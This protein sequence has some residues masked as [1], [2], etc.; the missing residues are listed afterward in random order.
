MLLK[1]QKNVLQFWRDIEIF[2]LPDMPDKLNYLET[3]SPL[4]WAI[5]Q[6]P[7]ED[8]KRRYI[9]YFGKQKKLHITGLI[10]KFTGE[11]EEKPDWM[12]KVTGDTCMAV[13]ILEEEGTLSEE[14]A[15]LQASYLHGL[16]CLQSGKKMETVVEMLEKVQ[17]DFID[18]HNIKPFTAE[19]EEPIEL[20]T[21]GWKE[22]ERE[23]S[24]LNHLNINSLECDHTVYCQSIIISK[25]IKNADTS[26]LNSF[27][28]DDLNKL[29]NHPKKWNK[30]LNNYLSPELDI[31]QRTDL[32]KEADAFFK[33]I[34]PDK[35]P[36]G[37]W[38]SNPQFGAYSAQLGAM[39]TALEELKEGGI[40]GI[41]GPPGTGKTTLLSD[42][43]ADVI[44]QRAKKLIKA[45]NILIFMPG[46]RIQRES[47]F[48]THFPIKTPLFE[49]TGIVVA[50]NNNAAVENISKEL[51]Q[52][53]KIDPCFT[54]AGYF[55]AHTKSMIEK[56]SWGLLAVALGNSEN[57]GLFKSNF[58][59]NT[60][61]EKR[62]SHYLGSLYN[63][64]EDID[65]TLGYRG[66]FEQAKIELNG[67]IVEY[68]T[69]LRS[70][71][72][73]HA[74]LPKQ[75]S[76]LKEQIKLERDLNELKEKAVT[77]EN[78]IRDLKEDLDRLKAE[79]KEIKELITLHQLGK[80]SFFFFQ[81]LFS[82]RSFKQWNMPLQ[83]Y[84]KDLN[85]ISSTISETGKEGH[86]LKTLL[87]KNEAGQKDIKKE[88]TLTENRIKA[89]AKKKETFIQDYGI[90][91]GNLPDENLYKAYTENRSA[92]HKSN[93]WS[94]EKLNTLRSNIFLT[95]L[96]IHEYA[97]LSNAK[98]FRNN[99]NILLEMLD[100]KATVSKTIA[101]SVWK[102][103]FFLVPVVSTS[104]ASVSRLFKNLEE[105]SI[106]WLLLDEAGQATVQSA[107]GIINRS[108]RSII[109]GDPLQIEPV[110]TS[111]TK[112]I[113]I[114]NRPYKNEPIWSPHQS[115][116]QQLA[117]RISPQGTE[118]EQSDEQKIWTGFPLRTHRRC[119]DP[120][121]TIA[122]HIAYSDQMVKATPDSENSA[123]LGPST[124]FHVAGK[125][126]E[127]KQVIRE[128]IELLKE[129]LAIIQDRD[130]IFVISPFK[131]VA[132]K[133][134]TE[135]HINF[136]KVKCGTIHTFQGK[137]T[138]T[139][140]LVLGSD[141]KSEG[142]RRWASAKPN[143]LNV[144]LTRAKKH[145][146]VIG[147][148]TLW[149]NC[150]NFDYLSAKLR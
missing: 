108:K 24:A 71:S 125:T 1:T 2:N 91:S 129:K 83:Q 146:Y 32:L 21:I 121:F 27:Y 112:L 106:G 138:D 22:L 59:F 107:A 100:G 61:E 68:E 3:G 26:F 130:N 119:A 15:Y 98:Q 52:R 80:P 64:P 41:N 28:L 33:T 139:V 76:D 53:D 149:Q 89:Y 8:A 36:M 118:M 74:A 19:T 124:W 67:L 30:G 5:P 122:N 111:P 116:A 7:L 133:C 144:A 104:L 4:P 56:E 70:A 50:S 137:E 63:N 23:I 35:M 31:K 128:E 77:L 109:I 12:E 131:S 110:M 84:L 81:K 62:F 113:E 43:V 65:H 145:F 9:L 140:F 135:L 78:Q 123:A 93:P 86:Q 79:L 34:D 97:V 18:R 134:R 69:F 143:M 40:M 6:E 105:D 82:S 42:I 117:D 141:P 51:P 102:T 120:M 49:D 13:L 99:I 29:I 37:R 55:I 150:S 72:A 85:K 75:L 88:L 96:K 44:V 132:D 58:W 127:N 10:E 47:D 90:A 20:G 46:E 25:K 16:K 114:L 126:V 45:N 147:N 148:R 11:S 57:R 142:A 87:N 39:N 115:S 66:K 54:E 60:K 38:P 14:G 101:T 17:E 92:F 94:S 95:S 48:L 73:F 136:P 103:F